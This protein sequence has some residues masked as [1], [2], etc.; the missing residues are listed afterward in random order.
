[1]CIVNTIVLI[2]FFQELVQSRDHVIRGA[3]A[4]VRG[5]ATRLVGMVLSDCPSQVSEISSVLVLT[6]M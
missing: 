6:V 5:G 2:L 1:M 3:S 4:P